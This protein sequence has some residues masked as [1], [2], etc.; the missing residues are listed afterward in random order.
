[1]TTAAYVATTEEEADALAV[2]GEAIVPP[3]AAAL[4]NGV[5]A[6]LAQPGPVSREAA[7]LAREA[8]QIVRGRSELHPHPKDR[9]FADPAW[10]D[11]P[12]YRRGAQLYL[13]VADALESLVE[14]LEAEDVDWRRVEQARF[15][16]AVL[17]S[18]IAPSNFLPTNPSALRHAFDT[19]GRSLVRGARNFVH[20]VRHNGGMPSQ[21]DRSAFEVGEDLAVT[22][23]EVVYRDEVMEVLQ[24]RPATESVHA[25][26]VLVVPPPI[27]RYY[28][29][30]LR[31]GRSFV[32]YAVSRGLQVFL[33]SWRNPG[34]DQAA[35]DLDT[36]AESILRAVDAARDIT[37]ADDVHAMGFCAGGIMLST[38]LSHLA[39]QPGPSPIVS[40]SFGVTLL[41]FDQ[42][43]PL[44]TFSSPQ[45]LGFAR[46]S[47]RRKG[48][49]TGRTLGR[50]FS[51][52]RPDDLVFNYVV[53]NYLMGNAPPVFDIL[54]WNADVTNLPADLHRQFLEMF[55][56]NA[57]CEAGAA[58]VLDTPVDLSQ[59]EVPLFVTGA[60]TDHITPWKGC[61]RTTQLMGGDAEFVL[62]NAGHI[63]SLVKPPGNPRPATTSGVRRAPTPTRGRRRPRPAPA[64]G[65]RRGA[66]G[67]PPRPASSSP[68]R[69]R[70]APTATPPL[71]AAPGRYVR[72]LPA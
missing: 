2:G 42:P 27:G 47:S 19:G 46:E 49:I 32:E 39:Q 64:A 45:M 15:A 63:A 41:D 7:S 61:Y 65:G 4:L 11:N 59:V 57:L 67:S 24:Y 16:V 38:V 43:A 5:A 14:A 12:A 33:V 6:A 58:T 23:G 18:A 10:A 36:Y 30:D 29:L 48:I 66:T 68:H 13:A 3:S 54:A 72:D 22:L 52:M 20:D 1:M 50:V 70:S 37:G 8:I 71:E 9:R 44:G 53:N 31:P 35:W 28:F 40:A 17:A 26:P 51:W 25:R 62:S 21:T 34:P 69:T 55:Q 56:T 60:I